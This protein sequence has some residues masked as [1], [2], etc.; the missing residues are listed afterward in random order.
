MKFFGDV[1]KT[2]NKVG[3]A[4]LHTLETGG[5]AVESGVEGSVQVVKAEGQLLTGNKKG[6]K[7][8]LD[9]AG[10]KYKSALTKFGDS[11]GDI[12]GVSTYIVPGLAITNVIMKNV[13]AGEYS[14]E[15]FLGNIP[16]Q[17]GE[18]ASSMVDAPG[19]LINA[20]Q[21]FAKGDTKGGI[22]QLLVT[23]AETAQFADNFTPSGIIINTAL[24][25]TP[26]GK[27][28][29]DQLS[30]TALDG[31]GY[32]MGSGGEPIYV[33]KNDDGNLEVLNPIDPAIRR[34]RMLFVIVLVVV[35]ILILLLLLL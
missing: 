11:V 20:G 6:A 15:E 23:G 17:F 10:D 31:I 14:P 12:V 32:L 7:K 30:K 5:K 28:M 22:M 9:K 4:A 19:D 18:D 26:A 24:S 16:K 25:K 2:L 34:R 3:G 21:M 29:M 1:G 8:S 27:K 35:I 13:G 33:K